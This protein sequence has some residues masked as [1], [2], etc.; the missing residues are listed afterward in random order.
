VFIAKQ[1]K[2]FHVTSIYRVQVQ[3]KPE[4]YELQTKTGKTVYV[5]NDGM[6]VSY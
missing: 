4:I 3:G 1:P 6:E 2:N 5:N